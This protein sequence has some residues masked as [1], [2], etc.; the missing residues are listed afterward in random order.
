MAKR[1]GNGEG[2]I[3]KR[4]D[5]TWA[6]QVSVGYDPVTG[7]LK[8]K[9]FYGKTRK[10]VADKMAQ[11]LQEVR[12]GTYIEPAQ[13]T[14]GE[15]LDKWLTGYKKGQLKP[16][17]YENYEILINVHIKPALGKVPLAKLQAH[18]LQ[19]FYNE[20]LE[21]GRADGKGGLS[22]RMV[23]YLHAIIRQALQQAVKEGL[24]PRNVADATSP[25]TVK[26][27]Q[28]RPLTEEELLTFFD[29]ARNDRLYAAY[30]L[31]ATTG[32]RRGELLGLCWDCVDLENGVIT[33]QRQ[34]LVLKEG[35][36][37]EEAT[38]SRS[39]RRSIVLTDDAI[40]ELKAHRKRQLQE[41]LLMGEAYQDHGLVFCKEDGT[42]LDPRE[43]TK[44][45][46]RHL[47]AAGLPRVRLHDLRHTHASLL[48]ARG[49]HPKIVQERLGHSSITMTLDL[50]SHLVPGLQEA[51]A[52]TLN[53]LL[54]KEKSHAKTQGSR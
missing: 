29:A 46:Q 35:I 23:R 26:N 44:R 54:S 49:V 2:S 45:F 16:G 22:T 7:K 1:R 28:M 4:P 24:L 47:E 19:T 51:A 31:A 53:G 33:V 40:R 52:A 21:K 14:F 27:K 15:W 42:P 18:M 8:R 50:Y 48:L 6:G 3:Y 41:R 5:G 37:L 43:F 10:E 25:P 17:T 30:V 34:L 9:S 20:K 38:K 36:T 11:A 32:L 13:T 39:G 12:S